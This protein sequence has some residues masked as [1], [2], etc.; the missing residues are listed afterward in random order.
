MLHN[1]SIRTTLTAVGFSLVLLT[2]AVGGLGL[3]ALNHA[4]VAFDE[5]SRGDLP[6]MRSL[7]DASMYLV[8]A[9]A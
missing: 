4:S 9:R 1:W 5:I 3:V 7:D 2:A 8:R 6:T